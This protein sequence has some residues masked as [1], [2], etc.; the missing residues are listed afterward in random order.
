[1]PPP[2]HKDRLD[3]WGGVVLAIALI[4]FPGGRA[5]AEPV[6]ADPASAHAPRPP[7]DLRA[8]VT[9]VVGF[10][11]NVP[12]GCETWGVVAPPGYRIEACT[13]AASVTVLPNACDDHWRGD[14]YARITCDEI[15]HLNGGEHQGQR[16]VRVLPNP[17]RP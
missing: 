12:K 6:V 10:R 1:M 8:D 3:L 5:H 17:P 16:W 2:D 11:S 15:G 13:A 9:A 4:A 14:E 7:A